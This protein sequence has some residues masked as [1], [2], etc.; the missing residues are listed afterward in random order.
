M[1]FLRLERELIVWEMISIAKYN[2][3]KRRW[4]VLDKFMKEQ[5]SDDNVVMQPCRGRK[6]RAI[7]EIGL[8][9]ANPSEAHFALEKMVAERGKKVS[10]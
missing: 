10:F 3:S 4:L 9:F 1:A 6:E 7:P 5:T 8:F 2:P